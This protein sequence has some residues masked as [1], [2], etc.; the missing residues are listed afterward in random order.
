METY[1]RKGI[2]GILSNGIDKK[3]YYVGVGI[4]YEDHRLKEIRIY[5]QCLKTSYDIMI[6]VY[7]LF[8]SCRFKVGIFV[9]IRIIQAPKLDDYKDS[10]VLCSTASL[11]EAHFIFKIYDTNLTVFYAIA[12]NFITKDILTR[13]INLFYYEFPEKLTITDTVTK[14]LGYTTIYYEQMPLTIDTA[15]Y[16]VAIL[17]T[18]INILSAQINER[19]NRI[20]IMERESAET[21]GRLTEKLYSIDDDL[22]H[23]KKKIRSDDRR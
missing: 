10:D 15:D 18:Q 1:Q 22:D 2:Y 8:Q 16:S 9:P 17:D 5:C 19:E 13:L 23:M 7:N 11:N 3:P 6:R 20:R 12:D 21:I 4:L 14:I